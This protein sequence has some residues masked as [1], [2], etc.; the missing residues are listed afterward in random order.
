MPLRKI[1]S[2]TAFEFKSLDHP[3][4]IQAIFT[5]LGGVSGAAL[6]SLNVGATVGDAPEHVI[7]NRR[8]IFRAIGRPLESMYDVW[9]VH[10]AQVAIAEAPR[11]NAPIVKADA[12][13]TDNPSVTLFM[14]FADCVPILLFD[15]H[16]RAI[17]LAHAGWLGTVRKVA[18]ATIQA[19]VQ[20]Y[21]CDPAE[22]R[23]GI[24]PSIGVDH[25]AVGRD[26]V[27][28]MRGAFGKELAQYTQSR[29]GKV[30][31]D[32]WSANRG[33]LEAQGVGQ[34]EVAGVCTACDLKHWYSHRAEGE[35]TGRFGALLALR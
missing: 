23:A 8:R 13:V 1:D 4:L 22:I 12:M 32:L 21:G 3:G 29:N 19:M 11:G 14:R 25:Y 27:E 34:I 31:L 15:P 35:G 26:V 18:S 10:S 16:R 33:L 30:Y 6:S 17:G 2:L 24:G 9:Q 28:Q 20:R 5:R 7:E